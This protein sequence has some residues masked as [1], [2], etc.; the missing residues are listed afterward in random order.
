VVQDE[1]PDYERW[2]IEQLPGD[3]YRRV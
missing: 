2:L 3:V 1:D